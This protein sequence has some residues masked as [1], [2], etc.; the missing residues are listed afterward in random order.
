MA[1][2]W[3][4]RQRAQS[5]GG[6]RGVRASAHGCARVSPRPCVDVRCSSTRMSDRNLA[7]HWRSQRPVTAAAE[8]ATPR[9]RTAQPIGRGVPT[10]PPSHRLHSSLHSSPPFLHPR[11]LLRAANGSAVVGFRGARNGRR[12]DGRDTGASLRRHTHTRG[13]AAQKPCRRRAHPIEVCVHCDTADGG[14]DDH[15]LPAASRVRPQWH[16]RAARVRPASAV[17]DLIASERE[18]ELTLDFSAPRRRCSL[19]LCLT[20]GLLT[21]AAAT[22]SVTTT[23]QRQRVE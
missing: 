10:A 6:R 19:W 16:C 9:P 8:R 13:E 17:A 15:S 3:S 1:S 14:T 2:Q 18:R 4:P 11:I 21:S 12:S 20:V 22:D 7:M 5:S 23:T